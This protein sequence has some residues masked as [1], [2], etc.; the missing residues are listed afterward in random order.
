MAVTE[1][2][3]TCCSIFQA[4]RKRSPESVTSVSH[5]GASIYIGGNFAAVTDSSDPELADAFEERLDGMLQE[6]FDPATPFAP[7]RLP[8][9][10]QYCKLASVCGRE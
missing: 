8:E 1:G 3:E 6:I 4:R 7:A 5:K 9:A 2:V 10:C